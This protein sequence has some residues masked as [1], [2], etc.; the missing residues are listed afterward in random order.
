M[1]FHMEIGGQDFLL[2]ATAISA[3]RYRE[4]YGKSVVNDLADC[5]SADE[6]EGVLVR[7]THAMVSPE[8]GPTLLEFAKLA[9][10]DG[11]FLTKAHV[12]KSALLAPDPSFR[13]PAGEPGGDEPF[14]EYKILALMV[15]AGIDM[16]LIY[17]LPILH[18]VAL[19]NRVAQLRDP[20]AK[21]YRPMTDQELA[22][23]YPRRR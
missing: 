6:T 16:A 2:D 4:N 3:I 22:Q 5:A 15:V 21:T 7:M 20:E 23:L 10:R 9:R 19:A 13:P 1:K 18:L 12:A 11:D 8:E 14:D 17:E